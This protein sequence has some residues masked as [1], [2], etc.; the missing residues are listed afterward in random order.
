MA[1]R[2]GIT[3]SLRFEVFKRDSFKCQYC[4]AEA[5]NVLLHVDHIEPVSKGGTNDITN[6][7]TACEGC[8]NGKSNV[9]LSEH[10]AVQKARTQL[11]ELQARREQLELMME[12]RKGLRSINDQTLDGIVA[13]WNHYTPGRYL[14]ET[15]R[16]SMSKLLA[17]FTVDELCAAMDVAARSYLKFD[18]EGHATSES[19]DMAIWKIGGICRVNRAS[20]EN[21]DLPQLYYIRG[22]LR[23]R[24][25]G[26]F[27]PHKALDW[28]K[29]ARTWDI[30]MDDLKTIALTIR[31]WSQFVDK[32]HEAISACE[33]ADRKTQAAGGE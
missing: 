15:G 28:L 5:P 20:V 26:Y 12:W 30:S 18:K 7:I 32:M 33:E 31:N 3:K 9:P 24:I 23:K 4:G 25:P 27:D 14:S 29:A 11:D 6:L 13:Y 17:K 21:P 8:N 2:E 1:K 22:I 19:C 16:S 10:A